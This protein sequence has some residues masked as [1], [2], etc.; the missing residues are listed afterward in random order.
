MSIKVTCPGCDTVNTVTDDKAGKKVSCKKC[1]EPIT[2]PA[3]KPTKKPALKVADEKP[4]KGSS[5]GLLIGLGCGALLLLVL[6]A[7]GGVGGY[8]FFQKSQGK[9]NNPSNISKAGEPA[10]L[11]VKAIEIKTSLGG[12]CEH[13]AISPDAR[14]AII[15]GT[16]AKNNKTIE[17]W[18][19]QAKKKISDYEAHGYASAVAISPDAKFAA[20]ADQSGNVCLIELPSGK[21]LR[22]LQKGIPN[23]GLLRF[24][25]KGDQLFHPAGHRIVSWDISGK[26]R[27]YAVSGKVELTAMSPFFDDGKK[28]ATGDAKGM[29]QIWDID[30]KAPVKFITHP[31]LERVSVL[32]I[33]PD[34]KSLYASLWL[35]ND[36]YAWDL[37]GSKYQTVK[38]RDFHFAPSYS[39]ILMPG[40]KKLAYLKGKVAIADVDTGAT[41]AEFGHTKDATSQT[42]AQ[43]LTADGGTMVTLGRDNTL[44]VWDIK[45]LK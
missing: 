9:T 4:K 19:L 39:A 15:G 3:A 1:E 41:I 8:L 26:E 33:S 40:G 25:P 23:S 30:Q 22:T 6:C 21:V 35:T 44:K 24:S 37:A 18:D 13:L 2:V 16:F 29:I 27:F 28:F 10:K 12:A 5:T 34:A 17:L 14:Y 31:R 45:E 7:G 42:T 11:D 38:L 20:Y 43:A 32:E 36:L